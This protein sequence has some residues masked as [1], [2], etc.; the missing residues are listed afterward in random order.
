MTRAEII[1]ELR[2]SARED[3]ECYCIDY[4]AFDAVIPWKTN[5]QPVGAMGDPGW[6]T[7]FLLVAEAIS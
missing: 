2:R 1:A 4:T 5:G 6:R 3:A 7:F